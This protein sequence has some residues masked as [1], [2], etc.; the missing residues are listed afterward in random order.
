MGW[1]FGL[2]VMISRVEGMEEFECVVLA[3]G[4]Q[5]RL[6]AVWIEAE[7]SCVFFLIRPYTARRTS[8]L[9]WLGSVLRCTFV[10]ISA[11]AT[12]PKMPLQLVRV[13]GFV[14][15]PD[16]SVLAF[17]ESVLHRR[18]CDQKVMSDSLYLLRA[19]SL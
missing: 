11:P 17:C 5:S 3:N 12:W 18:S 9:I 8:L 10:S 14:V 13:P 6:N 16:F 4:R 1:I 7:G 19:C 2:W 15:A